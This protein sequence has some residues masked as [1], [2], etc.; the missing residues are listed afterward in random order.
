[1][2]L[3][4]LS[5]T[6]AERRLRKIL[7][8]L[9]LLIFLVF[10]SL[11][12]I[13]PVDFIFTVAVSSIFF[14]FF[15]FQQFSR[16]NKSPL[17]LILDFWTFL[18][19][20][21]P[22]LSLH[23]IMHNG[24]LDNQ[25]FIETFFYVN[26]KPDTVSLAFL[27]LSLCWTGLASGI[28]FFPIKTKKIY[29]DFNWESFNN[30][31]LFILFFITI[32]ILFFSWKYAFVSVTSGKSLNTNIIDI[33]F[34]DSAFLLVISI[35]LN[36]SLTFKKNQRLKT[37]KSIFILVFLIC[38][39]GY[40][41]Y[42]GSKGALLVYFN[43]CFLFMI[44][45]FKTSKNTSIIFFS[46]S[47]FLVLGIL[48]VIGFMFGL[49]KRSPDFYEIFKSLND[50]YDFCFFVYTGLIRIAERLF[51]GGVK[52]YLMIFNEFLMKP[53]DLVYVIEFL[54]YQ[55]KNFINLIAPGTIFPE[56][57]MPSS[58]IFFN[59]INRDILDFEVN[60]LYLASNLNTQPYTIFGFLI[61]VFGIFT[62][63][64]I[65]F[66]GVAF[67][68]LFSI[69][70]SYVLRIVLITLFY[71]ILNNFGFETNIF[72]AMNFLLSITFYCICFKFFSLLRTF[73]IVK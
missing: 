42:G 6:K 31:G 7:N 36:L 12:Y 64:A 13:F 28:S 67:V 66:I 35:Y 41:Y 65:F 37:Q 60:E 50:F 71:S 1:M 44:S 34:L 48:A 14:V 11:N 40:T 24:L 52:Q 55:V 69:F 23:F 26:M 47:G 4:I 72:Y 8:Y 21:T 22:V 51:S 27:F 49:I 43:L 3:T 59:V 16:Y 70:S 62:P 73:F 61:I 29:L 17:S 56:S 68:T 46:K 18:F 39:F 63:I 15:F 19:I 30:F 33:L 32:F 54:S 25:I 58:N 45:V 20:F 5:I 53:Y 57:Y 2:I 38:I 10:L 9:S